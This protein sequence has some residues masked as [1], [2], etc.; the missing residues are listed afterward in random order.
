M[1][2][3][4]SYEKSGPPSGD[5]TWVTRDLHLRPEL[6]AECLRE[7]RDK[8]SSANQQHA[9]FERVPVEHRSS[10]LSQPTYGADDFPYWTRD[11]GGQL[12][13]THLHR[14]RC[15]LPRIQHGRRPDA[16][17]LPAGVR[18]SE[19]VMTPKEV[20]EDRLFDGPA[21]FTA[22][23]CVEDAAFGDHRRFTP[24]HPH[25]ED[26]TRQ[27][28]GCVDAGTGGGRQGS[29]HQE[30]RLVAVELVK[31]R[32]QS[33]PRLTAGAGGDSGRDT[34]PAAAPAGQPR[35]TASN[36]VP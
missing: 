25:V 36:C 15:I 26:D 31:L 7:L 13:R 2:F 6:G 9:V 11:L 35:Q 32:L 29:I 21:T 3:G 5:A 30:D 8:C 34:E 20:R 19:D 22:S 27:G 23:G 4:F 1:A 16:Q 18:R 12:G 28:A 24:V 33:L 10:A 14:M 17:R